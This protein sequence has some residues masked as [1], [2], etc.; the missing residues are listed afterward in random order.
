MI[1]VHH[2]NYSIDGQ[3]ILK[4]VSLEIPKGK[5]ITI[6]GP[7]GCGKSTLLKIISRILKQE[8]GEVLFDHRNVRAMD[9]K[10]LA[11]RMAV[12]PQKKSI[13]VDLSVEQLVQYGRYPHTGFGGRFSKEDHQKVEQ[14]M[15]AAGILRLRHRA[16]GT[17]SGG[18]NQMA[19]IAM[20]LAQDPEVI[21]LDEPTTYLDICYQL[22]VLEL[23]RSLNQKMGLTIVMVLHDINQAA[24]YSDI[25]YML[26]QG[27]NYKDGPPNE[28]FKPEAF[29]DVF[30]VDMGII[31]HDGIIYYDPDHT[32]LGEREIQ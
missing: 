27:E 11:R 24:R 31:P 26:K 5:I 28:I 19:W 22:E 3:P 6:V 29:R 25:V 16:I 15:E 10:E 30:R 14:A 8:S 20:C 23:V 21:L 7:N 12:L 17:L 32:V 2:I 9:T 4:D 18:E 1:Q 13:S